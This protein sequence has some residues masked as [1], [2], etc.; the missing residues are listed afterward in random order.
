MSKSIANGLSIDLPITAGESIKLGWLGGTYTLQIVAGA[1]SLPVALATNSNNNQIFGPYALGVVVRLTVSAIGRVEYN[2][3]TTPAFRPPGEKFVRQDDG[4]SV[5]LTGIDANASFSV[6]GGGKNVRTSFAGG[7]KPFSS[8]AVSTTSTASNTTGY[9]KMAAEGIFNAV[10]LNYFNRALAAPS[11]MSGMVAATETAAVNNLTNAYSPIRGGT[12]YNVLASAGVAGSGG[13]I[14]VTWGGALSYTPPTPVDANHPVFTSSD[15]IPLASLPR[16]DV[17]GGRPLG[18]GRLAF[19]AGAFSGYTGAVMTA[20]AG[21]ATSSLPSFRDLQM[22]WVNGSDGVATLA[23]VPSEVP[24]VGAGTQS[25]LGVSFWLEFTHNTALRHVVSVGDSWAEGLYSTYSFMPWVNV[26]MAEL[27]TQ[28]APIYVTNIGYGGAKAKTYLDNLD[29][30]LLSASG[31]TVTDVIMPSFGQNSYIDNNTN[32]VFN[33]EY[34]IGR[35]QDMLRKMKLLGIRVWIPNLGAPSAGGGG[36]ADQGRQNALNWAIGE[37]QK[38]YATLV[39]HDSQMTD[40][41]QSPPMLYTQ[42]LQSPQLRHPNPAGQRVMA[43]I[44][45]AAWIA[46]P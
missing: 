4:V 7:N 31:S 6:D 10:R 37:C 14:P 35:Q 16:T 41:G 26:A 27:S 33:V 45:K 21:Y 30:F 19:A 15:I 20:N 18:M 13:W 2:V 28:T 38:G 34:M 44:M 8:S 23:T 42:Y 5:T 40:Y 22:D 43:D 1:A 39:D 11:P 17:I 25:G 46:N 36:W 9:N 32:Y 24:A 29:D 3:G 12:A